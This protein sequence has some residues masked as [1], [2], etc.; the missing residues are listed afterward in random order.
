M[1]F[2]HTGICYRID[3]KGLSDVAAEIARVG[4]NINQIAAVANSTK[5]VTPEQL[6]LVKNKLEQ[7]EKIL[8]DNITQKAEVTK[9]LGHF[10]STDGWIDEIHE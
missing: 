7:I 10:F 4:N 9:K 6:K 2:I 1:W 8:A 3:Y 5:E